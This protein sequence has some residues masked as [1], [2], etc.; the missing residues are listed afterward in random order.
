MQTKYNSKKATQNTAKQ[1][2]PGSDASYEIWS[3]N[4]D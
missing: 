1:N 2:F 3:E 4:I